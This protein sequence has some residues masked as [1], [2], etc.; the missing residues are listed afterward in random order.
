[1][2]NHDQKARDM[3]RSILPSA[4]RRSSR[5]RK[6]GSARRAR[7]RN[8]ARLTRLMTYLDDLDGFE[9]SLT[10]YDLDDG[11]WDGMVEDRRGADKVAPLIRWAEARI[12]TRAQLAEGDYWTRRYH[13]A[14]LVGDTLIG[15]HAL[16]HLDHLFGVRNPWAYGN[17]PND[18]T[19]DELREHR[20]AD[21][22]SEHDAR[23]RMLDEVL[24]GADRHRLNARIVA[25]TPPIER[26]WIVDSEG[27][28]VPT[29]PSGY[30]P[31]LLDDDSKRWLG[32]KGG[33]HTD[34]QRTSFEALAEVHAEMSGTRSI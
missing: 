12:L 33:S 29:R 3:A 30:E 17:S 13:F 32:T 20:R 8:A 5:G 21:A 7:A 4:A 11:G 16:Q 24:A 19:S 27:D 1:M 25:L 2:R 34:P 10:R 26:H 14:V 23:A 15:R 31:W 9:E 28:R 18:L 6:R 22:H